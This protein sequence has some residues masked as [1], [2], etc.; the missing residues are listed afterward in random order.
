L[1]AN[2]NESLFANEYFFL[3]NRTFWNNFKFQCSKR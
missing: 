3:P 1:F 2:A